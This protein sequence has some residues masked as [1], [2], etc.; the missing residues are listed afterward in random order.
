VTVI[1]LGFAQANFIFS[2]SQYPTGAQVTLGL[3]VAAGS[4]TPLEVATDLALAWADHLLPQ[5][6]SEMQL[7]GV[8][9]KFGPEDT[10]PSAFAISGLAGELGNG[11]IAPNTAYLVSKSTLFGGRAGRGR[12]FMPGPLEADVT[13]GGTLASAR[14]ASLQTSLDAF[15]A[16]LLAD[17]HEPVLLHGVG[18]PITTPSPI[19]AF[20]A[21]GTVATQR[22]RL[23]R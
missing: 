5:Q 20:T 23:R 22:R 21:D 19:V 3:D 7:D 14:R 6:A 9:V 1:P 15:R 8:L 2:G 10:G 12:F 17:S 11:G 18:S 16:Q 4:G 13:Q